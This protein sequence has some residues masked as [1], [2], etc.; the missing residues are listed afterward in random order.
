MH[1][2]NSQF[3]MFMLL[4]H[5]TRSKTDLLADLIKFQG[6]QEN[7]EN[8]QGKQP[9]AYWWSS[10]YDNLP[11]MVVSCDDHKS[12]HPCDQPD[13]INIFAVIIKHNG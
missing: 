8:L 3:T 7:K 2:I 4:K 1:H 5:F 13:F 12:D 10:R 6:L 9:I 11:F